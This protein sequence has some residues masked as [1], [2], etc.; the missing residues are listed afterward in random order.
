M[1]ER[2][3]LYTDFEARK[4]RRRLMRRDKRENKIIY[5]F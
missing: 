2:I 4:R 1:K 3:I 5:R